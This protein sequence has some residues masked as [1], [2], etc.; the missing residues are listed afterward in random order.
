MRSTR[1]PES[2]HIYVKPHMAQIGDPS[3]TNWECSMFLL[4]KLPRNPPFPLDRCNLGTKPPQ[5]LS[6]MG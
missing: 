1:M 5:P 6:V 4:P 3:H 2:C